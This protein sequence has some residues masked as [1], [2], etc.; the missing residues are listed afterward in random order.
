M[1]RRRKSGGCSR[2]KRGKRYDV[3][4]PPGGTPETPDLVTT[5]ENSR[6]Y[7]S[8]DGVG[9]QTQRLRWYRG[10]FGAPSKGRS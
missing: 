10:K 7:H 3:H 9:V 4:E 1:G 2:S 6:V 8:T 5:R